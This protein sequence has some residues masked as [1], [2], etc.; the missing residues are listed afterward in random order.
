MNLFPANEESCRRPGPRCTFNLGPVGQTTH[1]LGQQ[2][3]PLSLEL[4]QRGER[5]AAVLIDLLIVFGIIVVLTLL[6][7]VASTGFSLSGWGLAI[8]LLISFAVR[9][10][11][12]IFFELRW[13]GTTPGKR[14]LGLRVIDRAGGRLR[15]DAVFARNLM[16]EVELFIPLS[17]LASG[18]QTGS[19]AWVVVLTLV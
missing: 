19:A 1:E 13:H 4:A 12:F 9:S 16:R 2:F 15:S 17:L 7:A 5:A 6:I 14:A 3:V 10:F 11:Y 8:V 18:E